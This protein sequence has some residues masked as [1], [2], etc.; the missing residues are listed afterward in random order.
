MTESL[1]SCTQLHANS[2]G[3][4]PQPFLGA[5]CSW[6]MPTPQPPTASASGVA[7]VPSREIQAS[8]AAGEVTQ[9]P[10]LRRG[11]KQALAIWGA[12][13]CSGCLG[14]EA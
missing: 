10:Q 12:H 4:H 9:T 14:T 11:A 1:G 8:V 13:P 7:L 6:A 2:A 5:P 3:R